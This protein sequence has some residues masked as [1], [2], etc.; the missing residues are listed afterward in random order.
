MKQL[1]ILMIYQLDLGSQ[2]FGDTI[3]GGKVL[4]RIH[5]LFQTYLQPSSGEDI[6]ERAMFRIF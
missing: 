5:V 2:S 4:R 1:K 6:K 3:T